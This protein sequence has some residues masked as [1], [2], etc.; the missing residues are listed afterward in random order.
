MGY[1]PLHITLKYLPF[2]GRTLVKQQWQSLL[3]WLFVFMPYF[4][5]TAA[6]KSA[7]SHLRAD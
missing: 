1:P 3:K 5:I 6:D 2:A 4:D 7:I